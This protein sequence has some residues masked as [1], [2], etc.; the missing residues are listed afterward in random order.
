MRVDTAVSGPDGIEK[1]EGRR[2]DIVF[3]DQMMPGMDGITTLKNMRAR[4]DMRGVSVIA[5]TADAVAGAREFYLDK[6]FDDYI[7]KPVK[8]D[9][10]ENILKKHLPQGLLLTQ[11]DIARISEAE[12]KEREQKAELKSLLVIN[13][14]SEALKEVKEKTDGIFKGTFVTDTA[15]AEKFL[16]KHDVEYVLVA[17][18]I[19]MKEMQ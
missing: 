19:Y 1:M 10:L 15:K 7:S 3:L 4:F 14:D 16:Q 9:D 12:Q 2:Y 13:P 8:A 17:K 18:E 6:G 11:E 5:L